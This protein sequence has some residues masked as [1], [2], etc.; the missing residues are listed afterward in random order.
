MSLLKPIC[1]H[2]ALHLV[3]LPLV[4]PGREA[5]GHRATPRLHHRGTPPRS[6]LL[7]SQTVQNLP[8][9][10]LRWPGPEAELA[11]RPETVCDEKPVTEGRT[12]T[13][14]DNRVCNESKRGVFFLK[15]LYT[16]FLKWFAVKINKVKVFLK[17]KD[18]KTFSFNEPCHQWHREAG[19]NYKCCM[20]HI[21]LMKTDFTPKTN[22]ML[23]S[24]CHILTKCSI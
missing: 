21:H 14:L 16:L 1:G 18:V 24:F 20:K 10:L 3:L 13:R 11:D 19:G 17:Y 9:V 23:L 8:R 2:E 6:A 22:K 15:W 12:C 4:C 7:L 5:S